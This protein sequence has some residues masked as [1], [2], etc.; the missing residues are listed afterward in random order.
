MN[1]LS[2]ALARAI[3]RHASELILLIISIPFL[4]G[5]WK[6]RDQL[7]GTLTIMLVSGAIALMKKQ[8]AQTTNVGNIEKAT[9]NTEKEPDERL[10]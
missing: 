3:D 9:V 10:P 8:S 1:R 5:Y 4:I 2:N 6:T 7:I